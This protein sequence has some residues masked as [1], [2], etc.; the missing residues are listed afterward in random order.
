M[1]HYLKLDSYV[2]DGNATRSVTCELAV[3]DA[4]VSFA[5]PFVQIATHLAV[6][7]IVEADDHGIRFRLDAWCAMNFGHAGPITILPLTIGN[8]AVAVAVAREFDADPTIAWT[9]PA[10]DVLAWCQ[11]WVARQNGGDQR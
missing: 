10:A 5:R 3:G 1:N 9:S 7:P 6:T 2:F 8:Q 11:R 4:T